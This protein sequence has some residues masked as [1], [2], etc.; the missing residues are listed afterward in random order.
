MKQNRYNIARYKKE[1]KLKF[2][3]FAILYKVITFLANLAQ[4]YSDCS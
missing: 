4:T 1:K 3:T 2:D